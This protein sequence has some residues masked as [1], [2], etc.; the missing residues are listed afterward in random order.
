MRNT[1]YLKDVFLIIFIFLNISKSGSQEL[2]MDVGL[3]GFFDNREYFN[4][5]EK[6]QTI[7]GTRAYAKTGI[8]INKNNEFFLGADGLY[9]FGSSFNPYLIKPI[10]YFHYQDKSINGYLGSFHRNNLISMPIVLL[11]DTLVYYRPNIEGLYFGY[12][13]RHFS[14]DIWIDWTSRQSKED[15]EIFIIGGS[16]ALKISSFF[17][18]HDFVFTHY[19]LTE[20]GGS[21]EH[22]HDNGG[23]YSRIGI[24]LSNWSIFDSLTFCSGFI[25]S[26][27]RLRN[28]YPLRYYKGSISEL[29]IQYHRMGAKFTNYFGNG[30]YL[31]TGDPLYEARNYSRLDLFIDVFKKSG[32]EG[33]IE[34]SVHLI[35]NFIDYSQKFTIRADIGQSRKLY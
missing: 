28:E 18:K 21:N 24:D 20:K 22:I 30:Q 2:K 15:R 7:F 31:I 5:Y 1:N 34:L 26:Y 3:F 14:Q 23:F 16:G 33:E 32:I 8:V 12:K 27:D 4:Y 35:N 25:L 9:E 6:D 11:N 13:K 19:A 10:T 17:Y 29:Y